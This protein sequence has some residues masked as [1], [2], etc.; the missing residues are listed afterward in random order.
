MIAGIIKIKKTKII[1]RCWVKK[2]IIKYLETAFYLT[3]FP[4]IVTAFSLYPLGVFIRGGSKRREYN[5]KGGHL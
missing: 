5:D 1:P 3:L 2:G 4:N